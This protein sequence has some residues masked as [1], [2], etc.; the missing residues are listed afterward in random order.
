VVVNSIDLLILI[1]FKASLCVKTGQTSLTKMQTC[2]G[3]GSLHNTHAY[4]IKYVKQA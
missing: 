3:L 2:I 4:T 1:K